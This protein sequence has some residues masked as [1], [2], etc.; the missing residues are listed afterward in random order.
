MMATFV[1]IA[2]ARQA[3]HIRRNGIKSHRARFAVSIDVTEVH[4]VV[5]CVPVVA[6]FQAT[7]QWLR[8]LKRHGHRTAVGVQFRVDDSQEVWFGHYYRPHDLITAAE[9]VGRYMK[10]DDPRG[11][12]ILLP[13]R[14]KPQDIMRVR[15]VP[16]LM[17]WRFFPG[18]K[19]TG[20]TWWPRNKG[21]IKVRRV[22]AS[23]NR[24]DA[25]ERRDA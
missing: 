25:S 1:H 21:Q 10:I 5:F 13:R 23:L 17:G 19:N 14:V 16:Q 24:K 6:N 18:S 9:A 7:F 4:R 15:E 20:T 8:E 22:V 11:F 3:P 2:D 12:E